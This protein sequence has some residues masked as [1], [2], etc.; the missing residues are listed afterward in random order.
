MCGERGGR[1]RARGR[2]G[3]GR[4]WSGHRGFGAIWETVCIARLL[5]VVVGTGTG[6]A[7]GPWIAARAPPCSHTIVA[8]RLRSKPS[9][10]KATEN[11][12]SC[13]SVSVLSV[14]MTWRES[15]RLFCLRVLRR[16]FGPPH[17]A[18]PHTFPTQGLIGTC[19]LA[20]RAAPLTHPS[21]SVTSC[22]MR[23][24]PTPSGSAQPLS[25]P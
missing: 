24:Q 1:W 17:Y 2:R 23:H 6:G 7:H 8:V 18:P 12:V 4:C 10:V 19:S 21:P 22:R 3:G 20:A 15:W 13:L 16:V 9:V 11:D 25:R 14:E 5:C